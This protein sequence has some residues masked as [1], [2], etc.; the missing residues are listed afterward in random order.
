MYNTRIVDESAL[1]EVIE[2]L[3]KG[4]LVAVPTE[5]VYGLA[6]D[7]TQEEA[8]KNI[9]KVKGRPSDNPLIVHLA[10]IEEVPKYVK[11]FPLLAKRLFERFSPGPLTLVLEKREGLSD[12]VSAGLPTIALRIPAHPLF[13]KLLK[14]GNLAL[15]APSANLSGFPSP[16]SAKHCY[17][18][19]QGKIP[20]ILEGGSSEIGI[21]STVVRLNA[22]YLE[23]LRPGHISSTDLENFLKQYVQE[24]Q[25]VW[26]F[27]N[28]VTQKLKGDETPASPGMKYRHY[29]P[30]AEVSP[31]ALETKEIVLEGL[32]DRLLAK[33]KKA[34]HLVVV[35][36]QELPEHLAQRLSQIQ[37]G[38]QGK[39]ELSL[40]YLDFPFSITEEKKI[41]IE[42]ASKC[43]YAYLKKADDLGADMIVV[44]HF[45]K[46]DR[47]AEAY[48][49]RLF[50]A[51]GR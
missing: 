34:L 43:L 29:A 20:F 45:D 15:A 36:P 2:A 22:P 26:S 42:G 28:L 21:E 10:S 38:L 47:Q 17:Q 11:S 25:E 44:P 37:Q 6:A 24:E 40:T 50:K 16:T 4:E 35:K 3:Q 5:T 8:L 48:H 46:E 12:L 51:C 1:N 9:F 13:S 18:D 49:N 30:K 27:K 7:I 14:K 39:V 41:Q 19:L 31:Y 32:E 33:N 23:L